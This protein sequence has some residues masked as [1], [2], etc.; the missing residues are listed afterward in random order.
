VV[1]GF[2]N[3]KPQPKPP[4]TASSPE[5]WLRPGLR[6]RPINGV[7]NVDIMWWTAEQVYEW[8]ERVSICM[9]M[10]TDLISELFSLPKA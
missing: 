10:L 9:R 5:P 4:S 6:Y 2:R 8:Y 3:F 7:Y 1:S